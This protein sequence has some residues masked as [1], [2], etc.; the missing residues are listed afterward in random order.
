MQARTLEHTRRWIDQLNQRKPDRQAPDSAETI[1]LAALHT[2]PHADIDFDQLAAEENEQI[3]AALY[4]A[5]QR[6][7]ELCDRL[8]EGAQNRATASDQPLVPHQ[9]DQAQ[10]AARQH[11]IT[12]G[13]TP[14]Q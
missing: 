3:A 2:V 12:G 8:R 6:A 7:A 9:H 14:G 4:A 10:D 11:D 5:E 13:R 1:D